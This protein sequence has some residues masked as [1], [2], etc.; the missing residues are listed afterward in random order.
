MEK[1]EDAGPSRAKLCNGGGGPVR[2]WLNADETGPDHAG[3]CGNIEGSSVEKPSTD[4]T[5]STQEELR[6][7]NGTSN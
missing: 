3:E 7:D 4:T 2:A 6:T 5:A 1:T